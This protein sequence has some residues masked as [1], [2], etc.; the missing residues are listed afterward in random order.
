MQVPHPGPDTTTAMHLVTNL[1]AAIC[2]L[3]RGGGATSTDAP[4]ANH[5]G[6]SKEVVMLGKREGLHRVAKGHGE[7]KDI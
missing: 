4:G 6:S 7:G 2:A 3:G 5:L 1:N